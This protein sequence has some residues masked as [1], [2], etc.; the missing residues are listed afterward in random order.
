MHG[1]LTLNFALDSYNLAML[2]AAKVSSLTEITAENCISAKFLACR[3]RIAHTARRSFLH[4][5]C[6]IT[7]TGGYN[8]I[9]RIATVR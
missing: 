1:H 5:F 9:V 2:N 3:Y 4:L 7:P 6:L 8:L